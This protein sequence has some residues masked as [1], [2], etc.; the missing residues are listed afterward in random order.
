[1]E[2]A[3]LDRINYLA[4][5][6]RE[7]GLADEERAEQASLRAEYVAEFRASLRGTLDSTYIQYPDGTKKKV[8]SKR[9]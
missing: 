4:K 7:G 3:K 8:E 1:M 2:K 5:K 6:Q 9:S